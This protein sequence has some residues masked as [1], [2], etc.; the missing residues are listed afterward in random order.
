MK[1]WMLALLMIIFVIGAGAYLAWYD[2]QNEKANFLLAYYVSQPILIL[3]LIIFIW[4]SVIL[5]REKV[6]YSVSM[7]A[8]ALVYLGMWLFPARLSELIKPFYF[9]K[10]SNLPQQ[11]GWALVIKERVWDLFG[12]SCSCLIILAMMM[13]Q[14]IHDNMV[15]SIILSCGATIFL[16]IVFFML[17]CLIEKIFF[18]KKFQDFAD[19]LRGG[20]TKEHIIQALTACILWALSAILACVFYYASGLPTLPIVDVMSIF[21]V[22]SLGLFITITPAGL[23][24]YEAALVAALAGYGIGVQDGIAFALGFHYVGCCYL[25]S[26]AYGL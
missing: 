16:L 17:P 12:F 18:L 15:V 13:E 7:R 24:T 14:F 26:L 9:K 3:I 10:R 8:N 20:D 11:Q 6:S 19:A 5:S 4:R 21:L 25:H 22:S 2:M 1:K 23:G